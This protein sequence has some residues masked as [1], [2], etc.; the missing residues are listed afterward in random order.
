MTQILSDLRKEVA[1]ITSANEVIRA[2]S[3]YPDL[4]AR[5]DDITS[6]GAASVTAGDGISV[7]GSA[8]AVDSSVVRTSR[9]IISG[10]G[11][12]GGG[13]LA[14]D[15]TLAVDGTV[16][17]TSRS[18]TAGSGLTG[19][20]DLTANRSISLQAPGSLSAA[21]TN[22]ASGSHTHAITA[23]AN[24]GQASSLL[25]TDGDG[26]LKLSRMDVENDSQVIGDT[27]LMPNPSFEDETV[28]WIAVENSGQAYYNRT[29]AVAYSGSYSLEVNWEINALNFF[30]KDYV[31]SPYI[32]IAGDAAKVVFAAK[33]HQPPGYRSQVGLIY[34]Y[35]IWYDDDDAVVDA[36]AF[37][38]GGSFA[39]DWTV[40][41]F[42]NS[43]PAGATKMRLAFGNYDV[44]TATPDNGWYGLHV[45]AI[46]IYSVTRV[47]G[48]S[49][50]ADE[51]GVAFDFPLRLRPSAAPEL[52][53]EIGVYVS[54]SKLVFVYDDGG[55][56]RYKY[57]DMAGTGTT[58][59]HTTTAP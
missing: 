3:G 22:S 37:A 26:R 9:A 50:E 54:G 20:G 32:S 39:A 49:I 40:Y 48:K 1:A 10:D 5:L 28:D 56:V 17:R 38:D 27:N 52:D 55:T 6:G 13:A 8:V 47:V 53:G 4:N 42:I 7:T 44:P 57:L 21:S 34:A 25:K 2:R 43:K 58:L 46:E 12:T 31:A 23:S 16:V 30:T 35:A 29:G 15:R 51:S 18:I 41:E 14:S 59:T 24:P 45:D 36:L 19:G 11:L 33:V